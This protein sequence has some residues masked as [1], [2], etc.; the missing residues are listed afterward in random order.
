MATDQQTIAN[1]ANAARSTGP[2]T[3]GG[4]AKVG[5]NALKH[6]LQ[7]STRLLLHDEDPKDLA[8]LRDALSDELRP[9]TALQ[10]TLF[11]LI[12]SKFWRL[13]RISRIETDILETEVGE[14]RWQVVPNFGPDGIDEPGTGA[15]LGRAF[16]R[17]VRD[18]EQLSHVQKYETALERGV[19]RLLGKYDE[20]QARRAV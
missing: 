10:R 8:E 4:K 15:V 1:K 19:L 3:G 13:M 18:R 12:V 17:T 20:L 9:S 5:G 6:G 16:R 7:S 14:D 2:K 11:D